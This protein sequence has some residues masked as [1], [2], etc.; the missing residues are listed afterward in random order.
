VNRGDI[1]WAD[2]PELGRRPVVILTRDPALPV[3]DKLLIAPLTTRIRGIPTEVIVSSADGVPR[4]S[5]IS[6]DNT[7]TVP[8]SVLGRR[9]TTLSAARMEEVC[10][11]LRYA[12]AC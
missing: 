12:T 5:A 6:L 9:I 7:K 11:A 8:K 4:R 1:W 2:D 10:E 3:V